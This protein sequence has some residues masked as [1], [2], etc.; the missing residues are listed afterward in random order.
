MSPEEVYTS[1]RAAGDSSILPCKWL[2]TELPLLLDQIRTSVATFPLQPVC[3]QNAA[4][5]TV[6]MLLSV[7]HRLYVPLLAIDLH[8]PQS[9]SCEASAQEA[10]KEAQSANGVQLSRAEA[11]QAWL[12]AGGD[13]ERAARQALRD[14]LTKVSDVQHNI[15]CVS[16]LLRRGCDVFSFIPPQVQEL[17]ALGFSNAARCHEGL[18]QSG[19]EV[20]GALALLQRPLLEPFHKHIWSDKPEPPVD[21][22][23][24]DKQVRPCRHAH[25]AR[26]QSLCLVHIFH[27]PQCNEDQ[28]LCEMSTAGC[29][30]K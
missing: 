10:G 14:R 19:G 8:L 30:G 22:H 9:R 16:L 2:K 28:H 15:P 3:D 27:T 24:P 17:C 1:R 18:R 23:H 4:E 12:R 6:S 29:V 13:K 5:H 20:R 26:V 11:K 7:P 25:Q 21:I